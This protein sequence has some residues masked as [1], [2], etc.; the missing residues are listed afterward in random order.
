MSWKVAKV[1][2]STAC[3]MEVL[4]EMVV[5]MVSGVGISV[6]TRAAAVAAATSCARIVCSARCQWIF[7][8]STSAVVTWGRG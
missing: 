4:G 1:S 6:E 3:P 5:S 7:R 8:V 2:S